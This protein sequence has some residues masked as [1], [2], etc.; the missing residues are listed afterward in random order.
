MADDVALPILKQLTEVHQYLLL[1]IWLILY[2]TGRTL[3]AGLEFESSV[4][5]M[6]GCL[7][8]FFLVGVEVECVAYGLHGSLSMELRLDYSGVVFYV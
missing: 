3:V 4:V 6:D 1:E 2:D 8:S 7:D 5:D